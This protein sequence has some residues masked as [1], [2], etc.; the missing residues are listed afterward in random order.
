MA[1][2]FSLVEPPPSVTQYA[3][4]LHSHCCRLNLTV[5]K[6]GL[7]LQ[8]PF[9]HLTKRIES[10]R[11]M[12][13]AKYYCLTLKI[14]RQTEEKLTLRCRLWSQTDIMAKDKGHICILCYSQS[15]V[16]QW[17]PHTLKVFPLK[18]DAPGCRQYMLPWKR[19]N[20]NKIYV[21]CETKAVASPWTWWLSGFVLALMSM[22]SWGIHKHGW[23]SLLLS[24]PM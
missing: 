1:S 4:P 17:S 12:Y 20:E 24:L 3:K 7:L 21:Q 16:I 18:V 11:L 19:G 14:P 15:Q 10:L 13:S 8:F 22:V 9:E 23:S 5:A 2:V 6:E